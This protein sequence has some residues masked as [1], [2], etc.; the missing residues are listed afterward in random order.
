M[1]LIKLRLFD[2]KK[3][4]GLTF[5]RLYIKKERKKENN[6]HTHTQKHNLHSFNVYDFRIFKITLF[7]KNVCIIINKRTKKKEEKKERR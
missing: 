7:L 4:Y 2:V 5:K 6:S 3:G 1:S